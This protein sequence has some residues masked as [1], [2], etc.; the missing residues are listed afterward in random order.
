MVRVIHGMSV[1]ATK[2]D[3]EQAGDMND[4]EWQYS[5]AA[6]A[7]FCMLKVKSEQL[8]IDVSQSSETRD[9]IVEVCPIWFV[10]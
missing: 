1:R 4:A 10:K 2:M 9:V 3:K 6:L 8:S 7:L 5:L